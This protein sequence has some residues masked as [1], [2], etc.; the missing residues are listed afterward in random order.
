MPRIT[1]MPSFAAAVSA[2]EPA[3]TTFFSLQAHAEPG[4]M[5]RVLELFAKRGLVPELWH[6]TV[7]RKRLTIDIEIAGLGDAADYLANCLRQITGVDVVLT[8]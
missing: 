3:Q 2:S 6:S 4:V 8:A 7:A 5:P 1:P